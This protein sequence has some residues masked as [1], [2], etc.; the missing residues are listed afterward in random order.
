M[1]E[2]R[3]MHVIPMSA[4]GKGTLFSTINKDFMKCNFVIEEACMV[5]GVVQHYIE[6]ISLYVTFLTKKGTQEK[7]G[8][9]ILI[10]EEIMNTILSHPKKRLI[11]L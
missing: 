11:Y 7:H 4:V 5:T 10:T 9:F 3:I 6:I 1:Y 8:E 2:I